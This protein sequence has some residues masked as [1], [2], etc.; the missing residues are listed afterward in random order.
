MA[1]VLEWET[2]FVMTEQMPCLKLNG[3]SRTPENDLFMRLCEPT[4]E[5]RDMTHNGRGSRGVSRSVAL[6][7]RRFAGVGEVCHPKH[8]RRV[9]V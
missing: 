2:G 1:I 8:I 6:V 3:Y 5:V 4:R 7:G 9:I